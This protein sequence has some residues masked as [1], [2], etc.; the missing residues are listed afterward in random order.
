[1]QKSGTR[2]KPLSLHSSRVLNTRNVRSFSW[3]LKISEMP[4]SQVVRVQ[5]SNLQRCNC[6]LFFCMTFDKNTVLHKQ[7][8][9]V[10]DTELVASFADRYNLLKREKKMH[11]YAARPSP[12][13]TSTT[14]SSHAHFIQHASSACH[15]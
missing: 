8:Q 14:R 15:V 9:T 1:M 12:G 3:T 13:C 5:K 6:T 10:Y 7:S 2:S 11:A 4:F